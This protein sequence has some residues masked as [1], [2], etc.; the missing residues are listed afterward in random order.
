MSEL[1]KK[2][3]VGAITALIGGSMGACGVALNSWHS[4]GK[5]ETAV[6]ALQAD[7]AEE[8]ALNAELRR[9]L[10]DLRGQDR[11]IWEDITA[12]WR[13]ANAIT[14]ELPRQPD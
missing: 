4:L 3:L 7:L 14:E 10:K 9:E 1:W 8:K 12:L 11:I 5:L 2:A 6:E 13:G